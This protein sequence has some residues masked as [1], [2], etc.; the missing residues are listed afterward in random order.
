MID[1]CYHGYSEFVKILL[2]NERTDPLLVDMNGNDAQVACMWGRKDN[3]SGDEEKFIAIE[4][5][6]S[7]AIKATAGIS[8]TFSNQGARPS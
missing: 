8:I 7:K 5:A 6:L 1:G 3:T 2:E 4:T